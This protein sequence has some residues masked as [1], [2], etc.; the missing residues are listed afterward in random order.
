M[1]MGDTNKYY[2]L[3][4]LLLYRR[5][6]YRGRYGDTSWCYFSPDRQQCPGTR[7]YIYTFNILIDLEQAPPFT[8]NYYCNSFY[9]HGLL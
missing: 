6:G 5:T 2:V 3:I 8:D 1:R 7:A 9:S 4:L